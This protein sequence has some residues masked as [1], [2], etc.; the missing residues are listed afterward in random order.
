MITKPRNILIYNPHAGKKRRL[1]S[2][3]ENASIE[4]I[5]DLFDQ[6]QIPIQFA[7]T[8]KI[9]HATQLAHEYRKKGFENIIAAGGD[10]TVGEVANALV[11]SDSNLGILPLGTFMNVARMLCI[12]TNLEMAVMAIKIGRIRKI[13]VG[14]I[15]MLSG[16][17]LSD[18]YYFLENAGI[19][20]EAH[21]QRNVYDLERGN[22]RNILHIM[23]PFSNFYRPHTTIQVDGK[24]ISTYAP[25]ISISNGPM[26]GV[27]LKMAPNSKLNDHK[28]T[29]SLFHM[30]VRE[31]ILYFVN[32][33]RT[34]RVFSA[35]VERFLGSHI[36]IVTR[37]KTY[38][39]ADARFFGTTPVEFDIIPNAL[40]VICGFPQSA[41]NALIK[42]TY[43]DP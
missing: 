25:F 20:L 34:G 17:T 29:L 39:H 13:D 30:S 15:T 12:P 26:T 6:Y 38:V 10:G 28:F 1:L 32:M 4:F 40:N 43:L 35:K 16:K 33:R 3:Q 9:G 37:N 5:K 22:I 14:S 24:S 21:L 23:K 36:K 19:G 18:P 8:K 27:S 31:M 11:G 2:I 42:R 41:K 7:P